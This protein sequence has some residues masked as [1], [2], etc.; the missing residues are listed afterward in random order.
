MRVVLPFPFCDKSVFHLVLLDF[1]NICVFDKD[2]RSYSAECVSCVDQLSITE[3][4][5]LVFCWFSFIYFVHSSSGM[6]FFASINSI[7]IVFIAMYVITLSSLYL[8]YTSIICVP[9]LYSKANQTTWQQQ[10]MN[11]M[12]MLQD[13]W[14]TNEKHKHGKYVGQWWKESNNIPPISKIE[15]KPS[16]PLTLIVRVT[17]ICRFV[18]IYFS[19]C[20]CVCYWCKFNPNC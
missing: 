19:L 12:T 13:V 18:C 10:R 7:C 4:R 5:S 15:I 11:R 16:D 8:L 20:A 3:I 9:L 1:V 6:F 17:V 2:C 14:I